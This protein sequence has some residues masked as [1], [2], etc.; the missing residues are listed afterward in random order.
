MD[1][2]SHFEICVKILPLPTRYQSRQNLAKLA[3][4]INSLSTHVSYL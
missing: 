1:I 2:S 4:G 3:L